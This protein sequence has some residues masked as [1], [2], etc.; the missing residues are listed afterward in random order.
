MT[1]PPRSSI[2]HQAR[3]APYVSLAAP[4][5]AEL[6][7]AITEATGTNVACRNA[8]PDELRTLLGARAS[9][10][11]L[12]RWVALGVGCVRPLPPM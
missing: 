1:L 5:P 6:A 12:D 10:T 4:I 7:T 11:E 9:D 8:T 3:R 2:Q